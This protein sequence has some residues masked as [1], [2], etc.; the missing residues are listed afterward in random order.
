MRRRCGDSFLARAAASSS[1]KLSRTH[2]AKTSGSGISSRHE[3]GEMMSRPSW[4][5]TAKTRPMPS[6]IGMM[7]EK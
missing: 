5:V 3:V 2:W 1:W 6:A 4:L 7:A